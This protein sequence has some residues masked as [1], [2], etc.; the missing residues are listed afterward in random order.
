MLS[1]MTLKNKVEYTLEKHENARN[2]DNTMIACFLL[3][4]Y[5]DGFVDG[6][7]FDMTKLK[8]VKSLDHIIRA[9]QKIQNEEGK[10]PPTDPV[11]YK[12]RFNK[13]IEI[14]KDMGLNPEMVRPMPV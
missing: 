6:R 1:P 14:R 3:D 7:Y 10:Y 9:R 2:N 8:E 5:S 12:K 13:E 11:V 4:W